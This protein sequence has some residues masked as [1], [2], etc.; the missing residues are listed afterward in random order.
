MSDLQ[1]F[2]RPKSRELVE[3]MSL[4]LRNSFPFPRLKRHLHAE[5]PGIV[6]G[7]WRSMGSSSEQL[8]RNPC[9]LV[10]R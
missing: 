3:A 6:S 2:S 7:V 5:I 8:M 9:H 10:S 4:L 1:T